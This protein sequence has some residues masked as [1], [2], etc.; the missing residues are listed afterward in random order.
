M[1]RS[2]GPLVGHSRADGMPAR[3]QRRTRGSADRRGGVPVGETGAARGQGI[4]VGSLAGPRRPSAEIVTAQ[5]V[6]QEEHDVRP[7]DA[8]REQRLRR[9][10]RSRTSQDFPA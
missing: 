8:L 4:D 9:C 2:A 7:A 5:I 10:A 1:A 3:Q 6:G